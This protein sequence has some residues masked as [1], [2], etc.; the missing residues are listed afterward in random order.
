MAN[1]AE[2]DQLAS[3]EANWSGSTLFAN[4]R[5]YPG[6]AGLGL[7]NVL[8]MLF[9]CYCCCCCCFSTNIPSL[10]AADVKGNWYTFREATLIK[11]GLLPLEK[12]STIKGE[13][14][15]PKGVDPF[16]EGTWCAWKQAGSHKSCLPCTKWQ[17]VYQYC[18]NPVKQVTKCRLRNAELFKYL[19]RDWR[20]GWSEN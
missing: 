4:I 19:F 15:L 7:S 16:L 14:L 3:S 11:I 6:S 13:N 20:F 12:G 9:F 2:L 1:S 10:S 18:I 17:K 5:A 8:S